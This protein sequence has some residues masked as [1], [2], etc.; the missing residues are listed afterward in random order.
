MIYEDYVIWWFD[1]SIPISIFNLGTLTFG[2]S[3]DSAASWE[4]WTVRL[5]AFLAPIPFLKSEISLTRTREKCY[6]PSQ[7]I[8]SVTLGDETKGCLHCYLGARCVRQQTCD[9]IHTPIKLVRK[10]ILI[11]WVSPI[12]PPQK[13]SL[14]FVVVGSF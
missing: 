1:K 2:F 14:V 8:F 4:T 13:S 11:H 12:C 10:T 5:D 7:T 9:F 6:Y 3:I